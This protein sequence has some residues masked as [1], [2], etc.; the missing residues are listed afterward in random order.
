MTQT[1]SPATVTWSPSCDVIAAQ[2]TAGR[3][4]G[5]LVA[6]VIDAR[7]ALWRLANC[8]KFRLK[9]VY[10]AIFKVLFALHWITMYPYL[11]EIQ[12]NLG[13]GQGIRSTIRANGDVEFAN[14]SFR[15][16]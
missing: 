14:K 10:E 15:R 7:R 13:L 4:L 9:I 11:L 8:T 12:N 16:F 3:T 6:G 5:M 1:L 2:V